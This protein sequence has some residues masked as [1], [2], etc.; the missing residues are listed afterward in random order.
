VSEVKLQPIHR[1]LNDPRG[2]FAQ[3]RK[4][5]PPNP[6][7]ATVELE[8]DF[9]KYPRAFYQV[10]NIFKRTAPSISRVARTL[11]R[12]VFPNIKQP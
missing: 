12:R 5:F 9:E 7:Q 3:V 2:F 4:R 6:I 8:G 10:A 11:A 1:F